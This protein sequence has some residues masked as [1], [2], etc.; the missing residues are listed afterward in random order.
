MLDRPHDLKLTPGQTVGLFGGTFDPPHQGHLSVARTALRR[1]GLA[2]LV[3]LVSPGNPLKPPRPD[4]LERRISL[5]AALARDG[6]MIVSA[7][8]ARLGARYSIDTVRELKRLY[9]RARFVWVMGA[10]ALMQLHR[11]AR[12]AE[13]MREIPIAVI[14]RPG[15]ISRSRLSPAARRFG[16]ARLP[17]SRARLLARTPPPAWVY[18]Q[19]RWNYLSST[20]LRSR[21]R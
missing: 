20:A 4:D 6:G 11:W 19:P 1:L 10:D 21:L 14:A 18:L 12:W 7:A 17:A 16:F 2:R 9:P 15:Y 3:W 13:L 8:E 5:V